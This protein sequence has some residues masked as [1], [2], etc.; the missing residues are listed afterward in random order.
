MLKKDVL[1]F[2]GSQTKTAKALGI[3]KSAVNQWSETGPIPL[4]CAIKAQA[5]SRGGLPL[6]MSMYELPDIRAVRTNR[7]H[8]I[9]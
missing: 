9:T 7:R 8:W 6:E 5:V 3:T 2:F 4:R 1:K